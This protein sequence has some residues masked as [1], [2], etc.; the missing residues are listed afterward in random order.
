MSFDWGNCSFGIFWPRRPVHY[1]DCYLDCVDPTSPQGRCCN[2]NNGLFGGQFGVKSG[3]W[4]SDDK[5][6]SVATSCF[7]KPTKMLPMC[8]ARAVVSSWAFSVEKFFLVEMCTKL[9]TKTRDPGALAVHGSGS[10]PLWASPHITLLFSVHGDDRGGISDN[11]RALRRCN[12][13]TALVVVWQVKCI[14]NPFPIW[15]CF[16]CART[17]AHASFIFLLPVCFDAVK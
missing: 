3:H 12:A 16:A 13:C 4:Q 15:G 17:S 14:K 11:Q 10:L 5:R 6:G 1:L 9:N 2:F 8:K 7:A